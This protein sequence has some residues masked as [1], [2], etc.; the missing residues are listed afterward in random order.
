MKR[1]LAW[2]FANIVVAPIYG[3]LH[4]HLVRQP[5]VRAHPGQ[6]VAMNLTGHT[7]AVERAVQRVSRPEA[8]RLSR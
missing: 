4:G 7:P 3:M 1:T 2:G 6:H 8:M 5:Q